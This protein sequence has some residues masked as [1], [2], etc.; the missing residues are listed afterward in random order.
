M[1]TGTHRIQWQVSRNASAHVVTQMHKL[2][3]KPTAVAYLLRT[4]LLEGQRHQKVRR[5]Y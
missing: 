4:H 2:T 1:Q 3:E 5:P